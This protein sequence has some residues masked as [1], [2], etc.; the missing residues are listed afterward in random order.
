MD[1][2]PLKERTLRGAIWATAGGNGAQVL[3]FILFV[4]ISRVVGPSAFGVVAVALLLIE[5]LRA[6]TVE[7]IAVNLVADGNSDDRAFNAGLAMSLS[8][9]VVAAVALTLAAP[10]AAQAFGITELATVLPALTPLLLVQAIARLYEAELLRRMRFRALAVRSIGAVGLGGVIGL[11]AAY[12]GQGVQALILQ[13][14]VATVASLVFMAVQSDWRPGL[15]FDRDGFRRLAR[16]SLVLA[17]AGVIT[18]LKQT[19]DGL[20]VAS[21][22]GAAAAGF[23]NLAKR[24]RLAFQLGFSTAVGRVSLPAFSAVKTDA[25]RLASAIEQAAELSAVVAFPVFIGVAAIAPELISVFLGPAWS[26][27]AAPMT[28]LM[29]GGALAVTTRLFENA[30]IVC[31]RRGDVV[32]SNVAVLACLALLLVLFGRHGTGAVAA[33]TA[34]TAALQNI[35]AWILIARRVGLRHSH[36]VTRHW[37]PLLVCLLML[38]MI[39]WLRGLI[40]DAPA[41]LR[42]ILFVPAGAAFYAALSWLIN[43]RAVVAAYGAARIVLQTR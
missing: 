34:A 4:L 36:Y 6:L 16:Q 42:L 9:S 23:Y 8:L 41:A 21:F 35:I 19:I 3:A 18:N 13:Q 24:T 17:P 5:T 11:S 30:L 43:R 29:I 27:A 38:A 39:S 28:L 31:D 40:G 32:T 1:E 7:S 33:A 10:W 14:W 22:A 2:R 15:T 26:E 37:S 25:V 12:A 20:A